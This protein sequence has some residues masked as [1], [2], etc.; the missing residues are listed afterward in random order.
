MV[1]GI[2]QRPPRLGRPN[3]LGLAAAAVV[4]AAAVVAAAQGVAVA[5][6]EEQQDQ[7]DD[8]PA[9]AVAPRTVVTHSHY[10]QQG[11]VTAFAVHSMLFRRA[12]KVLRNQNRDSVLIQAVL[13]LSYLYFNV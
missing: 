8:P 5:T 2:Q 11:F 3:V 6:A 1:F 7:N 12:E 9:A 4:V 10:L 13:A